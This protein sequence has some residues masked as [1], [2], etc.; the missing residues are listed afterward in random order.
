MVTDCEV[1]EVLTLTKGRLESPDVP[2]AFG[3]WMSCTSGQIFAAST[4]HRAACAHAVTYALDRRFAEVIQRVAYALGWGG[5]VIQV[6]GSG[7]LES[8]AVGFVSNYT[9]NT[10]DI[11]RERA[12]WVIDKAIASIESRGVLEQALEIVDEHQPQELVATG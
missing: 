10:G 5:E 1:L 2:F 12:L 9:R 3:D 11:T 6:Y 7:T 4:G 8:S